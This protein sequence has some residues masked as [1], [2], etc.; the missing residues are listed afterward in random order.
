M[1]LLEFTSTPVPH[2]TLEFTRGGL[3]PTGLWHGRIVY[4][5]GRSVNV[6]AKVRVM[7]ERTG[8]RRPSC[9]RRAR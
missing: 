7:E 5:A 8:W 6:W 1:E 9:S 2:G 4:G 3:E